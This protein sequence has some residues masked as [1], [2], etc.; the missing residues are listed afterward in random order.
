MPFVVA[1]SVR[2]PLSST[3][4][5]PASARH[6][7]AFRKQGKLAGLG[8]ALAEMDEATRQNAGLVGQVAAAAGR[9]QEQAAGLAQ[10]AGSFRLGDTP[11]R[12]GRVVA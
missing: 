7:A 10:E 2:Q 12:G 3:S 8:R 4:A 5:A 6:F 9:L 1:S 11:A